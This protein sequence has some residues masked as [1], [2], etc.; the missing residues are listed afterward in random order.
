MDR[1][2]QVECRHA[3][4]EAWRQGITNQ[5]IVMAT[6]TGKTRTVLS[7]YEDLATAVGDKRGLI[8]CPTEEQVKQFA[9][10]IHKRFGYYPQIEQ[11]DNHVNVHAHKFAESHPIVVGTYASVSKRLHKYRPD[12]FSFLAVDEAHHSV[13]R[14]VKKMIHHFN[15]RLKLGATATP[16]RLDKKSLAELWKHCP[17]QFNILDAIE[18]GWLAPI[19]VTI[20]LIESIDFGTAKF[21]QN[22]DVSKAWADQV[23]A[24][25]KPLH[26]I[27]WRIAQLNGS[28][29]VPCPSVVFAEALAALINSR[30]MIGKA[31]CVLGKTPARQRKNLV[32]RFRDGDLTVMTSVGVFDEGFD[33]AL[34]ST[35]ALCSWTKS[36]SR[37]TQRLGRVLR[38]AHA[39]DPAFE[40]G[41]AATRRSMIANGPKPYGRA[42][43]FVGLTGSVKL[44]T[45]M[46]VLGGTVKPDVLKLAKK[47]AEE[48]SDDV[49]PAEKIAEAQAMLDANEISDEDRKEIKILEAKLKS[50]EIDPFDKTDRTGRIKKPKKPQLPPTEQQIATLKAIGFSGTNVNRAQASFLIRDHIRRKST[51]APTYQQE[52]ILKNKGKWRDGMSGAE[53]K[54]TLQ[55]LPIETYYGDA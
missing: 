8:V 27:A 32:Q 25:E 21:R 16:E 14:E 48:S 36:V 51:G 50:R 22:G 41:D 7:C 17:Y 55:S 47:L 46:D 44:A 53:A 18:Q 40:Y 24:Q 52:R 35:I 10:D 54:Q 13:A 26:E 33:S 23:A 1:P 2:Y 43:D 20:E 12:Q 29:I 49:D 11:A 19:K 31:G 45:A 28:V 30:Y 15:A 37:L 39:G 38:T 5:V 34:V 9:K 3:V 4:M 6:G 42:L